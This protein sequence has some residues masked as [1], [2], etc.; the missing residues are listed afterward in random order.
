MDEHAT[1]V[2][3]LKAEHQPALLYLQQQV[4]VADAQL[5][6]A[7]SE[8]RAAQNAAQMYI[9]ALINEHG[10][11]EGIWGYDAARNALVREEKPHG[12]AI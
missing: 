12:V 8:A 6:L 1:G 11:P 9:N 10:L 2:L 3:V 5:R 7:Q 4:A